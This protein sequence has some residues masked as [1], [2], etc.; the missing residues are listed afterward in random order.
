MRSRERLDYDYVQT[1]VDTGRADGT[2][3]LL[4]EIGP[5]RLEIERARGGV[6]LPTPDQEVVRVGRRLPGRV[7]LAAAVRGVERA[8]LLLTGMCAAQMMLDAEVGILQVLPSAGPADV[9]KVRRMALA[10]G[11]PWPEGAGYGEVVHGLDPKIPGHAAFLHEST[12][13][14]RGAAYVGFDGDPPPTPCTPR[15]PRPTPT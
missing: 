8:D 15:S 5:L 1:L 13:L 6:T 11:V 9:G 10:L 14:L 3:R 2:L 4:A 12:V 7:P